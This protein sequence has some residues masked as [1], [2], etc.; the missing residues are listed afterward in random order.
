[1]ILKFSDETKKV[2]KELKE[3]SFVSKMFEDRKFSICYGAFEVSWLILEELGYDDDQLTEI[4]EAFTE[5]HIH[6]DCE[7]LEYMMYTDEDVK[8]EALELYKGFISSEEKRIPEI[9]ACRL[10]NMGLKIILTEEVK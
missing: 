5:L 1:M 6:C 8:K 10:S 4:C 7:L 2:I 9:I 3:N